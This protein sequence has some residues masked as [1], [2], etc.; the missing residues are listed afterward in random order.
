MNFPAELSLKLLRGRGF[1]TLGL[2]GWVSLAGLVLGVAC[3]VVSMAVVSGFESTLQRTV[4]DVTGHLQIL[5]L[6]GVKDEN[7]SA[8]TEKIKKLEP[9][10]VASARVLW[11]ESVAAHQGKISGT[12]LEGVDPEEVKEVLSLQKRVIAGQFHLGEEQGVSLAVIG[13]VLAQKFDLKV[14]DDFKVVVPLASELDPNSFRRKVGTFRVQGILDFGKFEFD[15]R[16][17]I[18]SLA[19]VQKV[20][21]VG[22]RFSGILVRIQDFNKARESS[23]N[24]MAALGPSYR[25]RDW[26]DINENIFEAM[27]IEKVVI[28]FVILLIIFAASFNVAS[29]LY[30][31][32]V[33][34]YPEIGILKAMGMQPKKLAQIFSMQG[35][36]LGVAGCLGGA[37]LGGLLCFA[38]SIAQTSLGLLPGSVYK[39]DHIDLVVRFWDIACIFFSTILICGLATLAP[40]LQGAKLTPVEGLRHA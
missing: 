9:N 14:G 30:I 5:P 17:I 2:T 12:L 33:Q 22:D 20:A 10:Y 36:F 29:S 15:E 37:L 27:K 28:F 40:A 4:S 23:Q 25:I 13:K 24:L 8:L 38:F 6:Q 39:L 32:V 18:A 1:R 16:L 11:V 34:R 21:D 3:L 26:R 35:F 7:G 19:S 31:S